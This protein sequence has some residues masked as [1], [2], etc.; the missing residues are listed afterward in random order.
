M[1]L[2]RLLQRPTCRRF[3]PPQDLLDECVKA[4]TELREVLMSDPELKGIV[5][6]SIPP[7]KL[8]AEHFDPT[9][10]RALRWM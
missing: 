1:E 6:T 2:N 4:N 3:R 5:V 9:S 10:S 8:S 7:R